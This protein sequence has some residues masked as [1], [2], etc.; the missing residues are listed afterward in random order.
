[1]N[2]NIRLG[3]WYASL[4]LWSDCFSL[5]ISPCHYLLRNL[6]T[7]SSFDF[8]LFL[9]EI[10]YVKSFWKSCFFCV[11]VWILYLYFL[12]TPYFEVHYLF[13]FSSC[14]IKVYF[15]FLLFSSSLSLEILRLKNENSIVVLPV[16]LLSASAALKTWS[17]SWVVRVLQI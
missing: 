4:F 7:K 14:V 11:C 1:M 16:G 3:C 10:N 12:S 13:I 17:L 9:Q 15:Y 2:G 8:F 6:K 5:Y